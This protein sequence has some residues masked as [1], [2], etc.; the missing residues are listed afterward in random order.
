MGSDGSGLPTSQAA[1]GHFWGDLLAERNRLCKLLEQADT[2]CLILS[3]WLMP[4]PAIADLT[5]ESLTWL[6]ASQTP[7]DDELLEDFIAFNDESIVSG[8]SADGFN[9]ALG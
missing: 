8:A 9:L 4:L 1:C 6:D 7:T 2:S 5:G 3:R